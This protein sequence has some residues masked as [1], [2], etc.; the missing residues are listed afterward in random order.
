M[1]QDRL[2]ASWKLCNFGISLPDLAPNLCI[3]FF[4]RFPFANV[5]VLN[6]FCPRLSLTAV[7]VIVNRQFSFPS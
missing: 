2:M 5:D 4:A 1:E 3:M 6:K 7:N